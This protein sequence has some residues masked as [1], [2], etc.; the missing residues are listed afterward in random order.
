MITI[1]QPAPPPDRGEARQLAPGLAC[2]S[3]SQVWNT[4]AVSVFAQP[5]EAHMKPLIAIAAVVVMAA[6]SQVHAGDRMFTDVVLVAAKSVATTDFSARKKHPAT[7]AQT[8]AT[9]PA[10]VRPWTGPDPT[11]G[12]GI[13]QLHEYQREYRCVIDEGYGRYTFCSNM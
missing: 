6:A 7:T 10:A 4:L 11:K 8:G 9:K 12:P 5:Q 1:R 13:E 3:I 2:P